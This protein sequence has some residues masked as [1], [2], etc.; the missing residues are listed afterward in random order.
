[1]YTQQNFIKMQRKRKTLCSK[2]MDLGNIKVKDRKKS[3]ICSS[4]Y[5]DANC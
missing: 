2:Y 3:M 1:M 5:L 4:S